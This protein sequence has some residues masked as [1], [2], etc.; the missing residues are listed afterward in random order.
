MTLCPPE[1][2][3]VSLAENVVIL[4]RS[5]RSTSILKYRSH[6]WQMYWNFR[7]H[8][9]NARMSRLRHEETCIYSSILEGGNAMQKSEENDPMEPHATGAH[10]GVSYPVRSEG[11]YVVPTSPWPGIRRRKR[12]MLQVCRRENRTSIED[13]VIDGTSMVRPLPQL[14]QRH[15]SRVIK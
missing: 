15:I 11:N 1:L 9:W 5:R 14:P 3:D 12:E 7:V 8:G 4:M 6:P 2:N 10:Q 13:K